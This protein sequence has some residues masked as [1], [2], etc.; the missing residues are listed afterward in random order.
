MP[1]LFRDTNAGRDHI[2]STDSVTGLITQNPESTATSL[3]WNSGTAG[4]QVFGTPILCRV[5]A[6]ASATPTYIFNANCPFPVL[7]TLAWHVMTAAGAA[8]DTVK[9]TDGTND[10]TNTA[11]VSAA[12]DKALTFFT[13]IDDAYHAINTGGTLRVVTASDAAVDV[14]VLLVRVPNVA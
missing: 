1:N 2:L 11:D 14:Y 8:S 6:S 5:K 13:S 4:T 3:N 9:I 10:I 7:V 12:S